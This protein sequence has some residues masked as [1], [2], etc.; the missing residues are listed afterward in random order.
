MSGRNRRY[1]V[2]DGVVDSCLCRV[3]VIDKMQDALDGVEPRADVLHT[4][5]GA[6]HLRELVFLRRDVLRDDFEMIGLATI[7][8]PLFDFRLVER[9]RDDA[10]HSERRALLHV[11]QDAVLYKRPA[12]L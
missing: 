2:G 1:R 9:G 5:D 11:P 4:L 10:S 8:I 3:L 6:A 7:L 12:V